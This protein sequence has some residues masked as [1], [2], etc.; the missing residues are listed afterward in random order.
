M[1]PRP[2]LAVV[3]GA[4]LGV[5]LAAGSYTLLSSGGGAGLVKTVPQ[6]VTT[7]VVQQP[8]PTGTQ[9]ADPA[10]A[11]APTATRAPSASRTP[12]KSYKASPA[13]QP[14]S[15]PTVTP[16]TQ[17]PVLTVP[18]VP[19]TFPTFPTFPTRSPRP[20]HSDD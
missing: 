17:T 10:V 16:S 5:A 9:E 7:V 6:P 1:F 13:P 3:I 14:T 2:N 8:A 15:T 4:V 18:A 12:A 20:T 19:P 11:Q